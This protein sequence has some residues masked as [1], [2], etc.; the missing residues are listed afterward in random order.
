M[1]G[2]LHANFILGH[3]QAEMFIRSRHDLPRLCTALAMVSAIVVVPY[4]GV[5][6]SVC[7]ALQAF[8]GRRNV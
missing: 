3:D 6:G 5:A 8:K 7:L 1:C 2:R 4:W